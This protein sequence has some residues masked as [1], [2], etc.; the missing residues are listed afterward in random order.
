MKKIIR[1]IIKMIIY[2]IIILIGMLVMFYLMAP[3]YEFQEPQA[4]QGS[5]LYN[6]YKDMDS[7]A[8]KQYNFQ[9]QS[10]AWG[11]ITDGRRN[12]NELI[13]SVYKVLNFD[14]VATSDYQ[15]INYHGKN[16]P[17]FIPTYEHGYSAFKTHQVCI[18]AERVLWTDLILFQTLSMKQWI[19]DLLD[20]DCEI[21]VLAHPLLRH[22]YTIEEMKYLTNY[23]MMEVLNN[24]RISTDHWDAALSS[25]QVVWL[26]GNDDAHD[27]LNPNDVGR[28][29]TMINSP[30]KNREDIIA[31]LKYGNSY[32]VDFY[33]TMDVPITERAKR[34]RHVPM[35][36]EVNL[37][38]DTL[39]VRVDQTAEE[40]H[41]IGQ[42][43]T[44]MH[45]AFDSTTASYIIRED[46]SYIRTVFRFADGTSVYLNPV[47]RH[48]GEK[49][50]SMRT[51]V[52][53]QTTTLILRI[54]YFLIVLTIIYFFKK[55]RQKRIA[56]DL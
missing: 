49:P 27:V 47:I 28:K 43:G 55:R 5:K 53:D 23:E 30:S 7:G 1:F 45:T 16:D 14:H 9:V 15:K 4:F 22:G 51:A 8:W 24:L 39:S 44:I 31:S 50:A 2:M 18:G 3:V 37:K 36:R 52:I 19:I 12:T 48:D 29:F 6:P 32:G 38:D 34:I 33:P 10:K 26:M 13:D 25:G 17:A 20:K 21:V 46:D 40:I 42:N 41:F 54:G 35:V 56:G 11:G